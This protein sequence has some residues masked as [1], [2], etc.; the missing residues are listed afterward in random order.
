MNDDTATCVNLAKEYY[1]IGLLLVNH[2]FLLLVTS[3]FVFRS[4]YL[5]FWY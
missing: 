5:F 2:A 4:S 1:N 3:I